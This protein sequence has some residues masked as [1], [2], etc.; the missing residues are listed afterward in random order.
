MRITREKMEELLSI[1]D[2]IEQA[3]VDLRDPIEFWLDEDAEAGDRRDA[4]ERIPDAIH[5]LDRHV[6]DFKELIGT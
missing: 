2:E 3:C 1:I 6:G 4:K 5:L